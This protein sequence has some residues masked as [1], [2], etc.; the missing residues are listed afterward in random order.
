MANKGAY[1]KTA[2]FKVNKEQQ[3]YI[4]QLK[5]DGVSLR[6]VLEYYRLFNTNETKRL[7]NREK[8]LVKHITELEKE[9]EDS[10]EELKEVRTKLDKPTADNQSRFDLQDGLKIITERVK[11]KY[12]SK[13]NIDRAR[14]YLET[15]EAD[16]VL[17]PVI[18]KYNI[19]DVE[20]FK[21]ELLKWIKF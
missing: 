10:K 18:S 5:A 20:T 1:N 15:N 19:K 4:K 6:D 11:I 13:A 16:R 3:D 9:L 14:D 8:Y 7:E 17:T 12:G 2:S 21:T